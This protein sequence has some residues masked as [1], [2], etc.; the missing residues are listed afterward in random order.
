MAVRLSRPDQGHYRHDDR[1]RRLIERTSKSTVAISTHGKI[2]ERRVGHQQLQS[3]GG[4]MSHG[5]TVFIA[6]GSSKAHILHF[7]R[8]AKIIIEKRELRSHGRR[9]SELWGFAWL[10]QRK[11]SVEGLRLQMQWRSQTYGG[12]VHVV[13]DSFIRVINKAKQNVHMDIVGQAALFK[14]NN[15]EYGRKGNKPFP[16]EIEDNAHRKYKHI[17]QQLLCYV[18]RAETQWDKEDRSKYKLYVWTT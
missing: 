10:K 15:I 4:N 12:N 6:S 3:R 8:L 14:V 17:G 5:G 1:Q 9:L 13:C 11:K 2:H 7:S 18:I 16:A